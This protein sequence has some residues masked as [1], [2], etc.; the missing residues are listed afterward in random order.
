MNAIDLAFDLL[1]VNLAVNL[2]GD[3]K[4]ILQSFA[5]ICGFPLDVSDNTSKHRPQTSAGLSRKNFSFCDV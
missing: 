1:A 3:A 5:G 2:F 4:N